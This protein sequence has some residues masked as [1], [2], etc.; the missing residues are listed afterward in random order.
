[1]LSK[2]SYVCDMIQNDERLAGGY[3]AVGI[4]QGGLMFRGLAQRCPNPPIRNLITFGS[5]HQGVYGVPTCQAATGSA[6]LCELIR[7][8]LSEGAY[9]PW[10]QGIPLGS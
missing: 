10:I 3:N 9:I 6:L 7:R 1:M 4:S 8:L 5:P 2:I